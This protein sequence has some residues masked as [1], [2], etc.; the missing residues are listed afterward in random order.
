MERGRINSF[1]DLEIWKR[2]VW[3][4]NEIYLITKIF[5]KDELY[6]IT[7]AYD[8]NYLT[9]DKKIKLE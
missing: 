2:S 9:L 4:V 5:P 8:Q 7:I 3:L 1:K 6:G